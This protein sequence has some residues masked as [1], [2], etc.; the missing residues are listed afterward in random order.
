MLKYYHVR[1]LF[2]VQ[3]CAVY[4]CKSEVEVLGYTLHTAL[5]QE[6]RF[7]HDSTLRC[8]HHMC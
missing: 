6:T 8:K 3:E 1:M 2:L 5:A 4:D 7:Q